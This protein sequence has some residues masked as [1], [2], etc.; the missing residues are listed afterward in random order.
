M[1]SPTFRL[2]Q[3]AALLLACP[4]MLQPAFGDS[5]RPATSKKAGKKKAK[6]A[7]K[8]KATAPEA[9]SQPQL[10][11][12]EVFYGIYLCDLELRC[13]SSSALSEA[14]Q[15]SAFRKL[16]PQAERFAPTIA[17][18]GGM[19]PFGQKTLPKMLNLE[20][21]LLKNSELS[22]L[23][24][25]DVRKNPE[26]L[27]EDL[28]QA[29]LDKDALFRKYNIEPAQKLNDPRLM[30]AGGEMSPLQQE[31]MTF[32]YVCQGI[33]ADKQIPAELGE[34]EDTAAKLI[35]ALEKIND[36]LAETEDA[37]AMLRKLRRINTRL[38]SYGLALQK[39][40]DHSNAV[41]QLL[42]SSDAAKAAWKR[43]QELL[44]ALEQTACLNSPPLMA[45]VETN[46]FIC[47]LCNTHVLARP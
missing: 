21:G 8:D 44:Q 22:K 47:T 32:W 19:I 45:A 1:I 33:P 7:R 5:D 6:K 11:E 29:F 16:L 37:E 31:Y 4:L 46:G 36:I 24:V 15:V 10:T 3:L 43:R 14:E 34:A 35:T 27:P 38:M 12:D 18:A 28:R 17:Q 40:R 30:R 13:I 2:L 42:T 9:A 39:N 26:L 41:A 25:E 20:R 23:S